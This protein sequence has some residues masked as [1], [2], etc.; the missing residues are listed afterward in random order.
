MLTNNQVRRNRRSVIVPPHDL[1]NVGNTEAPLPVLD[2]SIPCTSKTRGRLTLAEAGTPIRDLMNLLIE[3][4]APHEMFRYVIMDP[5]HIS[6]VSLYVPTSLDGHTLAI[7]GKRVTCVQLYPDLTIL[8]VLGAI[9]LEGNEHTYEIYYDFDI[10]RNPDT[11]VFDVD[12]GYVI[13]NH[14]YREMP[15]RS[16][17]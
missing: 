16:V 8:H 15:G 5:A 10:P 3:E 17:L 14:A 11:E 6:T 9:Y 13:F 7:N 2:I 4:Y 1:G 12:R